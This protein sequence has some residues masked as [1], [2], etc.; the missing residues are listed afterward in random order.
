MPGAGVTYHLM[1]VM[2]VGNVSFLKKCAQSSLQ[3]TT[4]ELMSSPE[5]G[6]RSKDA[7]SREVPGTECQDVSFQRK[8]KS[9][10]I[11]FNSP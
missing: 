10:C 11:S 1:V 4:V 8:K 7:D 2:A 3:K 6:G 9:D 5:K